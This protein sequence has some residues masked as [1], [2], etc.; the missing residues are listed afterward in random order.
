MK[1]RPVKSPPP[2]VKQSL[3]VLT[4]DLDMESTVKALLS[5]GE[6]LGVREL[7]EGRDVE[8]V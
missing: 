7:A 8:F 2:P 5:R 1:K 3:V 6:A 4:A